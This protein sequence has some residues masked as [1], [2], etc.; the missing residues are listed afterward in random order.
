VRSSRQRH[1]S[2]LERSIAGRHPTLLR[3]A[4]SAGPER[5]CRHR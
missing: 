1:G 5:G 4:R 2:G 3:G